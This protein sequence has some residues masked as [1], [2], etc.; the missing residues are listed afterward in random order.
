MDTIYFTFYWADTGS[1][2]EYLKQ[3]G[4]CI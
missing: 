2:K 3:N 1:I 4:E